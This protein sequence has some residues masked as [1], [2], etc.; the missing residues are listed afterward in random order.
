MGDWDNT[1][2]AILDL[3]I[4]FIE[5]PQGYIYIKVKKRDTSSFFPTKRRCD[6]GPCCRGDGR[7]DG[8]EVGYEE[9]SIGKVQL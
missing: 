4:E 9:G 1:D 6:A 8:N 3:D 5:T 7:E 2:D